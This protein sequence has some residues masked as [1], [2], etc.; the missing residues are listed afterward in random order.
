L[1]APMKEGPAFLSLAAF[2]EKA[3]GTPALREVQ[4]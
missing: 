1:L 3:G 4:P 2:E